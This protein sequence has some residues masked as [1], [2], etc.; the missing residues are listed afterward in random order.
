MSNNNSLDNLNKRI[1]IIEEGLQELDDLDRKAPGVLI[2]LKIREEKTGIRYKLTQ[3]EN[4]RDNWEAS[5]VIVQP[6]TQ[7]QITGIQEALADLHGDVQQTQTIIDAIERL[8]KL[9]KAVGSI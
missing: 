2:E 4:I 5:Q 1:E 8:I 6:P 3:L 9:L 7:A